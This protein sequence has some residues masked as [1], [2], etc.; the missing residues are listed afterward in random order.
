MALF[1]YFDHMGK[2]ADNRGFFVIDRYYEHQV[3]PS[4]PSRRH[5][6]WQSA[7]QRHSWCLEQRKFGRRS[8]SEEHKYDFI[9]DDIFKRVILN[10]IKGTNCR[11]IRLKEG[12]AKCH[13]LKKLTC[14][15]TLRLV[16]ICL[17][18]R[19]PYHQPTQTVY[20]NTV[21]LSHREGERGKLNQRED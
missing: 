21:Y 19:T 2:V 13:H 7:Y 10:R 17:R 3:P 1:L 11:K 12:N 6:L 5:F 16:F 14:K 15:G 18:P 20:V 8:Q 9:K 4:T